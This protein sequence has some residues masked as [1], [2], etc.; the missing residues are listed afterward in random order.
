M[1]LLVKIFSIQ[2]SPTDPPPQI[3][4]S[5]D[6]PDLKG[7][8]GLPAGSLS[9]PVRPDPPISTSSPPIPASVSKV[10]Q[11]TSSRPQLYLL[12][13]AL[14]SGSKL[15]F[16]KLPKIGPILGLVNDTNYSEMVAFK[17]SVKNCRL[18]DV[19]T[20]VLEGVL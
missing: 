3:S 6:P 1:L 16:A 10:S 7:K 15:S 8:R 13:K 11:G 14:A 5:T 2:D 17:K 19:T 18:Y 12:G 4:C 20:S 9:S